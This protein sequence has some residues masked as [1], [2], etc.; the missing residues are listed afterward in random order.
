MRRPFF[1]SVGLASLGHLL[2]GCNPSPAPA[3]TPD[4]EATCPASVAEALSTP[5]AMDGLKCYPQ[6]ACGIL[7]A[8]ATCTCSGGVF[9]CVDVTAK[10]VAEGGSPRCPSTLTAGTCP[11]TEALADQHGCTEPGLMCPYP[12]TC[13]A[14]RQYD[15]CVCFT[16]PLGDGQAGLR[17]ECPPPCDSDAAL[18]DVDTGA[19]D[20]PDASDATLPEAAP[21]DASHE[22][23]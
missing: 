6:Y 16:G 1:L 10:P 14:D 17:F 11:A 8:T 2:A 15:P 3:A 9:A 5:C 21:T 12:T 7:P 19:P 18:V 23:G 20:A 13:A 4:A 22:P